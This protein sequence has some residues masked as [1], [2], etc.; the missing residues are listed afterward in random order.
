MNY[1]NRNLR[2]IFFISRS[3]VITI[4][5]QIFMLESH[6]IHLQWLQILVIHVD[7]VRG[8]S[9]NTEPRRIFLEI[10]QNCKNSFNIKLNLRR[11]GLVNK[12][13]LLKTR[14][15]FDFLLIHYF[16]AINIEFHLLARCQPR[17]KFRSNF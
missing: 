11:W 7:Y 16:Y 13:N 15:Y 17:E 5:I 2:V 1:L 3:T 8:G 12:L 9:L 10:S 6:D 14:I 4:Q